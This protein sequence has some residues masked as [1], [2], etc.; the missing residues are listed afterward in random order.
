MLLVVAVVLLWAMVEAPGQL[1]TIRGDAVATLL[2]VA[3]WRA[4]ATSADYW[5]IFRAPSPLQHAWSLAIEEQFY[6]VWPL[7]G[8]RR[9]R[10]GRARAPPAHPSARARRRW[11]WPSPRTC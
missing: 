6:V 5:A 3:N 8:H 2:Y 4:I 7:A 11:P 9:R 10:G 1:A